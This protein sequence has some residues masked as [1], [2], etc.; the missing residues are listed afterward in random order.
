[1]GR[2]TAG[3]CEGGSGKASSFWPHELY[4]MVPPCAIVLPHQSRG[5]I[6]L[7]QS[8]R[9]CLAA[10]GRALA[11]VLVGQG[12][13]FMAPGL[14]GVEVGDARCASADYHC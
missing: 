4:N 8:Y 12:F 5:V 11:L 1:M 13:W 10:S 14:V 2:G 7:L 6:V 9:E 3:R